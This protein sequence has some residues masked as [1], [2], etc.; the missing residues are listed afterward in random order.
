MRRRGIVALPPRRLVAAGVAAGIVIAQA[1]GL[2]VALLFHAT[3]GEFN[4]IAA[5]V[6]LLTG[7]ALG[8]VSGRVLCRMQGRSWTDPEPQHSY[9]L[10]AATFAGLATSE[11]LRWAIFRPWDA[12]DKR[13]DYVSLAG[14]ALAEAA[15]QCG[16]P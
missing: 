14:A 12:A 9:A 3:D 1:T 10:A 8:A 13:L 6:S 15:W 2:V 11:A 16:S 7:L 4:R 5:L